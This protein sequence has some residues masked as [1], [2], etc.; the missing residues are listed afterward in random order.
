M[1]LYGNRQEGS[2]IWDHVYN[3]EI[4]SY[5]EE[6]FIRYPS[7]Q[8]TKLW[9]SLRKSRPKEKNVLARWKNYLT[10]DQRNLQFNSVI[11]LPSDIVFTSHYLNNALNNIHERALRLICNHHE[12]SFNS[13][14]IENNLKTIH[15]KKAWISRYWD[16]KISKW[17]VSVNHEW[18]FHPKTKH[19]N[20]Q[21]YQEL[22]TWIRCENY[23]GPQSRNLI[24]DNKISETT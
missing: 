15:K 8:Q 11:L 3:N 7:R 9:L 14:L 10:S 4:T 2:V 21:K 6:N 17:L 16:T 24:P 22:S 13:I 23:R 20:L 12:K 19:F 1:S 18:Y 5:S